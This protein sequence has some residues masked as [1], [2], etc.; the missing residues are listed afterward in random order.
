MENQTNAVQH[1]VHKLPVT[2]TA[3]GKKLENVTP[4]DEQLLLDFGISEAEFHSEEELVEIGFIKRGVHSSD[5]QL[6]D[7]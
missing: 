3:K 5:G 2:P 4:E 7:S 6:H 1:Q